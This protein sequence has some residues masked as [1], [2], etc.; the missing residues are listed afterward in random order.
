MVYGTLEGDKLIRGFLFA[1]TNKSETE[2]VTGP[3]FG[4]D[5]IQS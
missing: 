2:C 1:C 5:K 4:T 3:V